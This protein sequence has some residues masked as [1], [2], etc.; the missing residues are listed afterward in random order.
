VLLHLVTK[1]ISVTKFIGAG[2]HL[3]LGLASNTKAHSGQLRNARELRKRAVDCTFRSERPWVA[4][5]PDR[6]IAVTLAAPRS[7]PSGRNVLH[8]RT[9]NQLVGDRGNLRKLATT[10]SLAVQQAGPAP[11]HFPSVRRICCARS[12]RFHF[13]LN[14]LKRLMRHNP[15]C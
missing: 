13:R 5:M 9:V 4:V 14:L 8:L 3:G 11:I 6:I 7:N 10:K 15:S 2:R 12:E 1:F